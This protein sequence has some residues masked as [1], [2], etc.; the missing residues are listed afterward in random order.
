MIYSQL[1][2]NGDDSS[3]HLLSSTASIHL[4]AKLNHGQ[5]FQL[6]DSAL[7][8]EAC[9][10][11]QVLP[12]ALEGDRVVLGMVNPEDTAAIEYVGRIL[13]YMNYSLVAQPMAVEAHKALLSTYLNRSQETKPVQEKLRSPA[14]K[15]LGEKTAEVS[16][17]DKPTFI[18]VERK[19][20]ASLENDSPKA[21]N[22]TSTPKAV[23]P[24]RDYRAINQSSP[25][26]SP[27]PKAVSPSRDYRK[28]AISPAQRQC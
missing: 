15:T 12:L 16:P 21:D 11:H 13:S 10:Y 28:Q 5:I 14:A 7:S 2:L 6:I 26:A 4:Q 9:L 24:S 22:P 18:L 17:N 27:T 3:S 25:Q 19:D 23:S 20:L 1:T 8:F